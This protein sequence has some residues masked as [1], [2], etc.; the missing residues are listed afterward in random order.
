MKFLINTLTAWDEPPRARHQ[1]AGAL[2][3]KYDVVFVSANKKGFPKIKKYPV[4]SN[5]T[6]IQ[7]FFPIDVRIRYRIPLLN[8]IY[9]AWLFRWLRKR[10]NDRKVINFDFTA[11]KIFRYFKTVYYY[12]NDNFS[13][14]SRK[15]NV[16]PIYRYHEY[17]ERKIMKSSVFCIGTSPMIT[18]NLL[19]WNPSSYEILLG[20]PDIHEFDVIPAAK[21]ETEH[22]LN[23]GLVGFISNYNLSSDL[24]NNI[25][26]N[27]DCIITFIG[28][29]DPQFY[30]NIE[31]K[32]RVIRKG[33]LTDKELLAAVNDF[34]V[35]IAPY[36]NKKV[37]EGGIPNKMFIYLAVGKPVV[38]TKLKSLS[39]IDLPEKLIYPVDEMHHFPDLIVKAFNENNSELIQ[40]RVNFAKNNTWDLRM[41]QFITYCK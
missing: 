38:T 13:S 14:I 12:C 21:N 32:D 26:Q 2:A 10:Y 6:V 18:A 11:H 7:P 35:A 3:K 37:N 41:D 8:E 9:Q 20:G 5:L 36:A 19:K 40:S 39:T 33:T 24:V 17:C 28:P 30:E 34:D 15:I 1:V 27:V 23:I 29:V 4:H 16:W 31:K 25:L 22:P